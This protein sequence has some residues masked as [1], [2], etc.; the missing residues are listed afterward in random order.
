MGRTVMAIGLGACLL[1]SSKA[2]APSKGAA[3]VGRAVRV[4]VTDTVLCTSAL[5][6]PNENLAA[7]TVVAV[8]EVGRDETTEDVGD[9][10]DERDANA[11]KAEADT[12]GVVDGGESLTLALVALLVRTRGTG[13]AETVGR[14]RMCATSASV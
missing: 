7:E 5:A 13:V 4:L 11:D 2:W 12:A 9:D 6:N 10:E 8:V 1:A 3:V 14:G